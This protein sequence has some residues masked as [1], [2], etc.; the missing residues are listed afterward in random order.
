MPIYYKTQGKGL[1]IILLHGWGFNADIWQPVAK[2]LSKTYR[3]T[4]MDFPGYGR[5]DFSNG[6]EYNLNY[7]V[8]TV[9]KAVPKERAIFLGWSLGGLVATQ[10]G[11]LHPEQVLG[12]VNVA[13]SPKFIATENWPGMTLNAVENFAQELKTDYVALLQRFLALQGLAHTEVEL[14]KDMLLKF[15][16]PDQRVLL[17]GLEILKNTD[18]RACLKQADE[19]WCYLLGRLDRIVPITVKDEIIKL[20]SQ[21]DVR[22]INGGHA[23]FLSKQLEFINHLNEFVK[24]LQLK[25][26]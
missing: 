26:N 11:L 23:F 14:I 25:N 21:I 22:V 24:C 19:N 5:S 8:E 6:R 7:L 3:V 20:N 18:F 15:G 1:D 2:E 9:L 12:V 17:A 4:V 16:K 10:I 13:S